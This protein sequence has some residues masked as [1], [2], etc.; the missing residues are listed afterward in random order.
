MKQTRNAAAMNDD[1]ETE[2]FRCMT[3]GTVLGHYG[4]GSFGSTRC[5]KCR[6]EF[7]F[8]LTEDCATLMRLTHPG[9]DKP[10]P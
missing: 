6:Q 4:P 1:P 7:R 3:C 5:A 9:K 2:V 10:A 8:E